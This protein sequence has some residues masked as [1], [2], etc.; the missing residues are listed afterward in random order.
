[1]LMAESWPMTSSTRRMNTA[2][3][4]RCCGSPL[5]KEERTGGW[6]RVRYRHDAQWETELLIKYFLPKT[7]NAFCEVW[8]E[9]LIYAM[10]TC[11]HH[12]FRSW[13]ALGKSQ[14]F[15]LN[16]MRFSFVT[17]KMETVIH[18]S[19]C[20]YKDSVKCGSWQDAWV[21]TGV[22]EMCEVP[23]PY[24]QQRC[25]LGVG[26]LSMSLS[27]LNVIPSHDIFAKAGRS[28]IIYPPSTKV[29][30]NLYHVPD[31]QSLKPTCLNEFCDTE[32]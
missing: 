5:N 29:C 26:I 10:L 11:H 9:R 7:A 20:G 25:R 31:I 15:H 28:Q 23:L 1:M 14:L 16:F 8:G 12:W 32:V 27:F 18:L 3:N 2:V 24:S 22:Q 13:R 19:Q 6:K 17:F 30:N 21:R 4:D